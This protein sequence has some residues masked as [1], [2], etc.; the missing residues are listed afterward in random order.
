MDR[1]G[2]DDIQVVTLSKQGGM[3]S[4]WP[5]Q[6]EITVT[7]HRTVGGAL[8]ELPFLHKGD[9]ITIPRTGETYWVERGRQVPE[10]VLTGIRWSWVYEATR[11]TSGDPE[12]WDDEPMSLDS[13]FGR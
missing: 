5:Q 9:G 8:P 10:E 2:L 13:K 3:S 12:P 4:D 7:P 6:Y 11:D 1:K